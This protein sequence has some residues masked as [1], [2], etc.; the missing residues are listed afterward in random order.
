MIALLTSYSFL[1]QAKGIW[2]TYFTGRIHSITTHCV[3]SLTAN[4]LK[5]VLTDLV[6]RVP[7]SG[8]ECLLPH[9]SM[10]PNLSYLI[11]SNVNTCHVS[12]KPTRYLKNVEPL[13][14]QA[15]FLHL[16]LSYAPILRYSNSSNQMWKLWIFV[17][18]SSIRVFFLKGEIPPAFDRCWTTLYAAPEQLTATGLLYWW[19]IFIMSTTVTM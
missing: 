11:Q 18:S 14:N 9:R 6:R 5:P 10:F 8:G 12:T 15:N 13:L 3:F 19:W 7:V 4:V 2:L 16:F 17:V 1:K